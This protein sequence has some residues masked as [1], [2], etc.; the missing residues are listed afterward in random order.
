MK[1]KG[2]D[3]ALIVALCVTAAAGIFVY[4]NRDYLKV[5]PIGC[6]YKAKALCAGL[7]VQG[8]PRQTIEAEDANFD[9]A[10]ALMRASVDEKK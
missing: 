3:I 10:F 2:K 8:L 9:P 4:L 6:A 7:F 1:P 5:I